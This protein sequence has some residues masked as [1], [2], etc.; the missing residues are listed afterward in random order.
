MAAIIVY[1]FIITIWI[2]D[3]WKIQSKQYATLKSTKT[4][5]QNE[6][7]PFFRQQISKKL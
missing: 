1:S 2:S 6:P 7:P 3:K 5:A 4:N